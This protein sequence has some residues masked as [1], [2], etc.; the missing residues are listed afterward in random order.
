MKIYTS[1]DDERDSEELSDGMYT[2]RIYEA[3]IKG[4]KRPRVALLMRKV[5]FLK[6]I[7]KSWTKTSSC[8]Y[9]SNISLSDTLFCFSMN[10]SPPVLSK[11]YYKHHYIVR[12]PVYTLSS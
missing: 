6:A 8:S 1:D 12:T 4:G 10:K 9:H 11:S 7:V 2:F 5:Y 3:T